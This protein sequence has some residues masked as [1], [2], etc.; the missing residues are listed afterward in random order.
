MNKNDVKIGNVINHNYYGISK[1]VGIHSNGFYEKE[2]EIKPNI[3][4][5]RVSIPFNKLLIESKLEHETN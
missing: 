2:V 4:N 3:K 5:T 1:I